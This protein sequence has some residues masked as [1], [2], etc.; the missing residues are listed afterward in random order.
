MKKNYILIP[1]L[2]F[3]QVAFAQF[4]EDVLRFSRINNNGGARSAA[5]GGAFGALG[6]DL[7]AAS[8]NPAGI[9][10]YRKSDLNFT[11]LINMNTNTAD[12]LASKRPS[13]QLANLGFVFA[14]TMPETEDNKWRAF[15]FAF[16]YAHLNSFNRTLKQKIDNS[17]S[18]LL[19]YY[20][21][22]ANRGE[23]GSDLDQAYY[24]GPDTY[25]LLRYNGTNYYSILKEYDGVQE[26]VNQEKKIMENGY[27]G[28][29]AISFGAN[30]LDQL[31]LGATIGTQVISYKFN[32]YYTEIASAEYDLDY[33][34]RSEYQEIT[35]SGVNLKVGAIYKPIPELRL[36]LAFHTPTWYTIDYTY[37]P[38]MYSTLRVP[39]EYDFYSYEDEPGAWSQKVGMMTP[40]RAIVSASTVL[41]QKFI[42]SMDYEYVDYS[43][44][45][46]NNANDP[47]F[48]DIGINQNISEWY[49]AT[50]NIRIGGEFRLNSTFSLRA[51]YNWQQ[52]PYKDNTAHEIYT[53]PSI[54]GGNDLSAV[55]G[56]FGLNFKH[57]YLDASYS[58]LVGKDKTVFY[59]GATDISNT[60]ANNQTR[61][62][63]GFKF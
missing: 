33:F 48:D 43:S 4:E 21:D 11:P 58:H 49:Q 59:P 52:S 41:A 38:A 25:A 31:Y 37:D 13:V 18:S 17:E 51:G 7:S 63:L 5:M 12:K 8:G 39:S 9:G 16:N 53:V 28:E 15:N 57:W 54:T 34:K 19:D 6:G 60:Y 22:R 30:Y 26:Y 44:M 42:V 40:W 1:L 20:V 62:T 55:S 56:G 24:V 29:Y 10:V 14:F 2:F 32:S 50:H 47:E 36:G 23:Q 61:V 27:Q 45:N 35:G 46:Y 3:V